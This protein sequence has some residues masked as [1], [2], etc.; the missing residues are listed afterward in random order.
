LLKL[1]FFFTF[2]LTKI[3]ETPIDFNLNNLAL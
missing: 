1:F 2:K 3:F